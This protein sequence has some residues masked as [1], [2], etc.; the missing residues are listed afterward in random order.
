LDKYHSET[1]DVSSWLDFFLDG[2]AIIA[3][4]AI[5]T[6]QKITDLRLRDIT[7]IP[8]L[9]RRANIGTVVLENLYKVPIVTVHTIQEWTGLARNNANELI[10]SFMKI[11][12]LVQTNK[13]IKYGRQF[14]YEDYLRLFISNADVNESQ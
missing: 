5:Q 13:D 14:W 3:E 12:I 11:G 7:K 8:T 10:K 2:V 6:T 1:D 9:G 4:K